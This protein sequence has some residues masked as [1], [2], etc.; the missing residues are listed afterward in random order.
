MNTESVADAAA[1]N[2][3]IFVFS[4]MFPSKQRQ[5]MSLAMMV[6]RNME[7]VDKGIWQTTKSTSN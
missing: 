3:Y 2:R 6:L 4:F 5:T 1:V 7:K